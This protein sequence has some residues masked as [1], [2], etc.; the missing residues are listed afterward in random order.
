MT[1]GPRSPPGRA[2]CP[3]FPLLSV[4][5]SPWPPL[6]HTHRSLG[7]QAPPS[8]STQGLPVAPC[9]QGAPSSWSQAAPCPPHSSRWCALPGVTGHQ[10]PSLHAPCPA[11]WWQ[12]LCTC[13]PAQHHY[14]VRCLGDLA[15]PHHAPYPRHP[16]GAVQPPPTLHSR[17]WIQTPVPPGHFTGVPPPGLECHM[18]WLAAPAGGLFHR[19]E[20]EHPGPCA[21]LSHRHG[22][23]HL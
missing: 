6:L 9:P 15:W 4:W 3:P 2:L 1:E 20:R 22:A 16:P 7:L 19:S 5:L 23:L 8:L 11:A 13:R 12:L 10:P 17:F 21:L 14:T 18:P